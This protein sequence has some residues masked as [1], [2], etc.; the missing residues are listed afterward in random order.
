LRSLQSYLQLGG[1]IS[2]NREYDD[3]SLICFTIQADSLG[4]NPA[5]EIP[6]NVFKKL[7]R[8][9]RLLTL[10]I[11]NAVSEGFDMECREM[12]GLHDNV[13]KRERRNA[14]VDVAKGFR[15]IPDD[16]VTVIADP[17][18]LEKLSAG[19]V[20]SARELQRGSVNLR[21]SVIKQLHLQESELPSLTI[22]QYDSF[23][24]Y[25]KSLL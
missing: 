24:G 2:R 11:T 7:I 3:S 23:L 19:A 18:L 25:M 5:F 12:G 14:F 15:L 10:T 8:S 21:K 6:R 1:R 9:G 22:G 13:C 4:F 16:T 17:D 20:I